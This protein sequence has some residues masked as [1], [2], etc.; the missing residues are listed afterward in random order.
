MTLR[1]AFRTLVRSPAWTLAAVLCL[2]I[3][4]GANTTVF[5]AGNALVLHPV[6][7]PNSDRLVMLSEVP[8]RGPDDDFSSIAP[9]N[10]LDWQQQSRT[11]ERVAAFSWWD[12]NIT[13]IT[14]PERVNG[15]RVAPEFFQL[16]GEQPAFGRVFIAAEGVEGSNN[17]VVLSHPLWKRRFGGDSAVVGSTVLLNG[18]AHTIIGVMPANFIFPAGTELWASMALNGALARERDGRFWRAIGRLKR[19]VSLEEARAEAGL[20]GKRLELQYPGDN[21]GWGL[22]VEPADAYYGRHPRPFFVVLAGCVA[23]VLLI[24]CAN[25][26]NLLLARAT[27]RGREL[28]VRVALGATRGQ[29]IR[30]MLAES[31]MIAVAGGTLGALF[32]LWGV[33]L[34]RSAL[35]AELV[36]FNPGWTRITMNGQALLFTLVASVATALLIGLV[37]ALVVS[38]SDPQQALKAGG[39]RGSTGGAIWHR[40]R[41][42]LVIGEIALAL[43]LLAGTGLMLRS[44]FALIDR[45]FGYRADHV[46]TMQLTMPRARV[47]SLQSVTERSR[48]PTDTARVDFLNE[49]LHRMADV[50][51]VRAAGMANQLPPS[52]DNSRD[53]IVLEGQALPDRTDAVPE[54]WY[55]LASPGYLPAMGMTL[56]RGRW[57]TD[58]DDWASPRVA[59]VSESMVARFWPNADAIGKRFSVRG[60]STLVTVVGVVRDVAHNPNSGSQPNGPTMY[61]PTGQHIWATMSIVV[62]VQGDPSTATASLQREIAKLDPALAAGDVLP[63]TRVQWA[64]LSPQRLT[65][66]TLAVFAGVAV[67]LAA[68][69]IYGVMSYT[70]AQRTQ[71]IGIRVA[72]GAQ[73]QDVVRHVLRQGAVMAGWGI[74]IGLAAGLGLSRGMTKLLHDVSPGDPVTF[75]VVSVLLAAVALVGCYL[76]ARRAAGVDPIV[77]LREE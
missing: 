60:D 41:S 30:L 53:G 32:S 75:G 69:G 36:R 40:M 43:M 11:L 67:L 47:A 44:F 17:T 1:Y 3:G 35:P 39:G 61:L 55:A 26:G 64:S 58:H 14:E 66:A 33:L 42:G 63:L 13:G 37:P 9:A 34:F 19:G 54:A 6:P 77:A 7:T 10:L 38:R 5:T 50:P 46:L 12:V 62:R 25:V 15:S 59:V 73:R 8:P 51:G 72:L 20:I 49:L 2:A 57:F 27:A 16:L 56:Q 23:F 22:R 28:S 18:V 45:D 76:P 68:I 24:A 48:Y 31:A 29:L 4:I 74:A 71:E 21:R 52:F 70:V 65:A